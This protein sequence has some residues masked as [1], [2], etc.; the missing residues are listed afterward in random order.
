M[1]HPVR[2]IIQEHKQNPSKGIYSVCSA[3]RF[4]LQAAM[5]QA[6]QDNSLLLVE[7][8]SNQVDQFGGYTGMTPSDFAKYV[9]SIAS[10]IGLSQS[11]LIL[12]GDHLGP[13]VW[14]NQPGDIP[15]K[16]ARDQIQAYAIAGFTK[17]HLDA[18]MPLAGDKSESHLPLD[19]QLVAHRSAELCH[20]AEEALIR[21]SSYK[22][23]PI[24][25]IG[26]DVPIPG[27]ARESLHNIR[28]T[29]VSEVEEII[30]LTQEAFKKRRLE[31]AW[32]RVVAVVVQPGVEFSDDDIAEYEPEKAKK[33]KDYIENHPQM[34]YEAHSTDYQNPYGLKKMVEDHLVILKV[35]P[36]LTYAFREAVFSLA[37]IER[38]ISIYENKISQSNIIETLEQAM[39]NEPKYWNNHYHGS[40]QQKAFARK[41]SFSDRIRYY[42]P[43]KSVADTLDLLLKNL[44]SNLIPLS[45]IDQY[46]PAQYQALRSGEITNNPYDFIHH[47]IKEVLKVYSTATGMNL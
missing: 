10:E 25:I 37:A 8:T 11:E 46:M 17:I 21:S 14:Q 45:L 33:L 24:Y 13:N 32:Q 15:M 6:L 40:D 27:G 2:S 35:G 1:T 18:S 44:Q 30:A 26:T 29:P 36:W 23:K 3:N 43:Q 12:G 38:E 4:V 9:S 47:R 31:D 22:F 19:P 20:A 16:N 39:L 28:V 42:W 34:V 5:M 7:A 41:Y